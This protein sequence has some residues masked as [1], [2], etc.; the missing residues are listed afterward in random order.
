MKYNALSNDYEYH[1]IYIPPNEMVSI[2]LF[3]ARALSIKKMYYQTTR[4]IIRV[5]VHNDSNT[6]GTCVA[7]IKGSYNIV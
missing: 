1:I 7:S 3:A 2:D 4:S 6:V 5:T